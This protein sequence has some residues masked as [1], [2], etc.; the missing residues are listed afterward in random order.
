[1]LPFEDI[2]AQAADYQ[3]VTGRPLVTLTYAQSLDGS[4]TARRGQP[5]ALSGPQSMKITHQLRAAHDAILVGI[6]TI[7]ADDPR[8]SV[9]LSPGDH[10]QP[11]ILDS[12]L[13]IPIDARLV[14]EPVRPLWIATTVA[15]P[16]DRRLAL[17]ARGVRLFDVPADP[18]SGISLTSLLSQL[19]ESGI[20]SLMVEGGARVIGSFLQQRL[21]NQVLLTITP[22]FVGGLSALEAPISGEFPRLAGMQVQTLGEDLIVWGTLASHT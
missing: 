7:L 2:L 21:A 4:L 20:N 10:P 11:V 14:S 6:G 12:F 13:R 15:A 1:M 17:L 19:A 22:C 3:Q 8:L 18:E 16:Q 9:R 5:L